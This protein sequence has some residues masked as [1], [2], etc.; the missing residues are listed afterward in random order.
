MILRTHNYLQIIKVNE[1]QQCMH[2]I[3]YNV[4]ACAHVYV[5][6]E[7]SLSH[8]LYMLLYFQNLPLPQSLQMEAQSIG[9]K[10]YIKL[11]CNKIHYKSTPSTVKQHM[12]LAEQIDILS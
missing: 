5:A 7:D 6:E 4:N 8:L 1:I 9:H 2:Q 12:N 11:S 3:M 10:A